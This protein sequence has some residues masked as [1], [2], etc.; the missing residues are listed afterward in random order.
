MS[1]SFYR[2]ERALVT[3]GAGF[4]GSHLSA[5]LLAAGSRVRVL[6]DLSSGHRRN[7]PEGVEFIEGSIVDEDTVEFT[8]RGCDAV[9]HLA[10]EVS[11]PRTV[12]DP[13]RAFAINMAGTERVFRHAAAHGASSVV[14]A[15][16]AA[17]YGPSPS[18]PSSEDSPFEC[19]SPYAAHKASG[20]LLL[21]ATS[22]LGNFHAASLRFFN[23]FGPRQDP[24]SAYAAVISA[25]MD[26]AASG[27]Q[28]IVFGDGS[29]TRDF[30]PVANVVEA[31][32]RAADPRLGL[33]GRAFNVA[34]G[35]R[36]SLLD[37]LGALS[38]VSGR[39]LTPELRAPR[40]GDVPHSCAKIDRAVSE[41]G[42]RPQVG[43]EEGLAATWQWAS[44]AAAAAGA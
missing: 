10:A 17:V 9:F 19:A 24:K 8:M 12:E 22:R 40:A 32:R 15:S 11:V 6:D 39:D 36:R 2:P 23:V 27:R 25:F 33:R 3:G 44:G 18:I 41:L 21:Q 35:E 42:F 14:F 30:V 31:L 34:L 13:V 38:A 29:Q 4:I 20:E 1:D 26:A 43:F 5:A 37:L 28:P 7:L 16:S